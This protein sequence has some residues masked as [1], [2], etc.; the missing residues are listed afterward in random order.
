MNLRSVLP[1]EDVKEIGGGAV[2]FQNTYLHYLAETSAKEAHCNG[3]QP[4]PYNVHAGCGYS[5]LVESTS[6]LQ[7][8]KSVQE[9]SSGSLENICLV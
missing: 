3:K 2:L 8:N 7:K 9:P 6:W 1:I 5:C 4:D